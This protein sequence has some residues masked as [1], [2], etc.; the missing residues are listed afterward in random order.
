MAIFR[1]R[2]LGAGIGC[3]TLKKHYFFHYF[4]SNPIYFTVAK[5]SGAASESRSWQLQISRMLQMFKIRYQS[6]TLLQQY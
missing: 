1:Y 6:H 3:E 2:E 5:S 4:Y